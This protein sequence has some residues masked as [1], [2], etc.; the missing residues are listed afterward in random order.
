MPGLSLFFLKKTP[1]RY[2]PAL[3]KNVTRDTSKEN[4][5]TK[6]L[7]VR[8]VIH[9]V[10]KVWNPTMIRTTTK[11]SMIRCSSRNNTSE[12]EPFTKL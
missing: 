3:S 10:K 7:R 8:K 2:Q 4:P 6:S 11:P 9:M 5:R 12:I 1:I